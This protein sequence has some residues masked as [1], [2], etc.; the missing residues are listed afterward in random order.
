[1]TD[2][3]Q[4]SKQQIKTFSELVSRSTLAARLGMQYGT[5]R[6]IYEAL[7]Y[8]TEL[9]YKDYTT[10]YSR[11]DI[12]A[13]VI[14]KPV[15]YTWRG[16]LFVTDGEEDSKLKEAWKDLVKELSLKSKFVRL[17]KLTSLGI[18][19]VL[20][21]GFD[22]VKEPTQFV[23][24]VKNGE[25]K[26]LYA[27]PFGEGD[28]DIL[29]WDK[30]TTSPRYGLPQIYKITISS[31]SG[32][33]ARDLRVHW[34]RI[35]HVAGETLTSEVEGI[36]VLQKVYNRLKDLEKLVGGSA[37]M[38]WRGAR[39]GYHGKIDDDADLTPTEEGKLKDQLDEYEHNLRRFLTTQGVSVNTLSQQIS[40]PS[41]HVD[42]QI[43]MISAVTG[44]PKRILT[45]SERGELSS[46]QDKDNW[47][48]QVQSRREEFAELQI[49]REF[50]DRMIKYKVLPK[51]E[52]SYIVEWEDLFAVGEKDKAE[53][54]KIRATALKEYASNPVLES[55]VTPEAFFKYFIGLKEDQVNDI[56]EMRQGEIIKEIEEEKIDE[57][58]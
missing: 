17:D 13:A 46:S 57:E 48:T 24:P 31:D 14:D 4:L 44:I 35:I 39:P 40:D 37:E 55:I 54:G 18:Y 53:V 28:I 45:G 20:L 22:D 50:T 27:K 33:S 26:L 9:Q 3:K 1:M 36:P 16:D 21:L 43:Q 38:F 25:R 58:E 34:S 8:D 56:T 32:D 11:Q 19:G 30:D 23:L 12:A 41:S 52:S 7:G 51:P 49:V 47:L 42:I 15:N 10:Q 6:D 29:T 5:S 2:T